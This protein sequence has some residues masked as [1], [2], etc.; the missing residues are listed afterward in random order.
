MRDSLH[1]HYDADLVARD[2][3]VLELAARFAKAERSI[4]RR[5]ALTKAWVD[6]EERL[7]KACRRR[8]GA[9]RRAM[10]RGV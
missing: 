8:F 3:L 5:R 6:K 1:A 4:E 10:R 7:K 2:T 9:G